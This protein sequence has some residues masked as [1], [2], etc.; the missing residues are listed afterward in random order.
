[1]KNNR[2]DLDDSLIREAVIN[3]IDC[4]DAPAIDRAW[5]KIEPQL[6]NTRSSSVR[7]MRFNWGRAAALAAACLVVVLGGYAIFI[8]MQTAVPLADSLVPADV[9]EEVG[10]LAF[11]DEAEE[12]F[13]FEVD[14]RAALPDSL[15]EPLP[16]QV[17]VPSE[18]DPSPPDWSE[19]LD[20]DYSF[21]QAL[22]LPEAEEPL[23]RGA[24][25]YSDD[26]DLLHV[27]SK[28]TIT[29]V[30]VFLDQLEEYMNF[31]LENVR[32]INGFISFT[33]EERPGLAWKDNGHSQALLVLSGH[34]VEDELAKIAS[35]I[36]H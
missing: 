1:M 3:E 27:K 32:E 25:Y 17:I 29:S 34:L 7:A 36:N 14:D 12:S 24:I 13:T 30:Q 8:N 21:G 11:E 15:P 31:S 9:V 5:K 19:T 4:I 10:T 26:V 20:G 23:Y 6:N 2:N 35:G 16:G 28:E 33:V 22:L 18:P